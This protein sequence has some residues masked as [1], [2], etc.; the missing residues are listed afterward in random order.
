MAGDLSR[1]IPCAQS[2]NRHGKAESDAFHAPEGAADNLPRENVE[3]ATW[4][5]HPILPISTGPADRLRLQRSP[6]PGAASFIIE[7]SFSPSNG[8]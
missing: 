6:T 7:T 2:P 1:H 8:F 3:I 5:G 4:A